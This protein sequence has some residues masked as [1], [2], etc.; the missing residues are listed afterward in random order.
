MT[1]G[2]LAAPIGVAMGTFAALG[3]NRYW[4]VTLPSISIPGRF[5]IAQHLDS[6]SVAAY[7][8]GAMVNSFVQMCVFAHLV[9]KATPLAK[10]YLPVGKNGVTFDVLGKQWIQFLQFAQCVLCAGHAL[11]ALSVPGIPKLFS[12]LQLL[13]A[14]VQN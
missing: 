12:A 7:A 13:Y 9:L 14:K 6:F 2:R 1:V 10:L 3:A 8:F 4:G 5:S 11:Y